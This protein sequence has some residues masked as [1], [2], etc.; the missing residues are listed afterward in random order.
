M[1]AALPMY[2]PYAPQ[3]RTQTAFLPFASSGLIFDQATTPN[4]AEMRGVAEQLARKY[5]A[6]NQRFGAESA[7][8]G[9]DR[10]TLSTRGGLGADRCAGALGFDASALHAV[11]RHPTCRSGLVRRRHR[12]RA[13]RRRSGEL[14]ARAAGR[15]RCRRCRA[16]N[17]WWRRRRGPKAREEAARPRH[18]TPIVVAE[19]LDELLL[20]RSRFGSPGGPRRRK[21]ISAMNQF[22]VVRELVANAR[23]VVT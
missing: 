14:P 4:R 1:T 8:P 19:P 23:A 3:L 15:G 6:T 18:V 2:A 13:H 10:R 12:R 21:P 22:A 9:P 20:P 17:V 5:P 7:G 11:V 16:R